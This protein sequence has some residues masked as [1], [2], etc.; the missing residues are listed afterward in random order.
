MDWKS[1][2]KDVT[3]LKISQIS[4]NVPEKH[5]PLTLLINLEPGFGG[6]LLFSTSGPSQGHLPLLPGLL[7]PIVYLDVHSILADAA[8]GLV[9][10]QSKLLLSTFLSQPREPT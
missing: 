2:C 5:I 4:R 8:F 6:A 10:L 1:H 9:A 3:M 7:Q